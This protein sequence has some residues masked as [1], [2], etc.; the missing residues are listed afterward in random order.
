MD[1]DQS[2]L[3]LS[4]YSLQLRKLAHSKICFWLIKGN[5]YCALQNLDYVCPGKIKLQKPVQG[6]IFE[7]QPLK[8]L[9]M[10]IYYKF[11]I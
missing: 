7:S 2:F 10:D 1:S 9:K 11:P 5:E 6:Q 3:S 4:P 8:T